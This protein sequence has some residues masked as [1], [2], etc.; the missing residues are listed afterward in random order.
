MSNRNDHQS[1][2]FQHSTVILVAAL[3]LGAIG[4]SGIA[5]A[6]AADPDISF[7]GTGIVI[8]SYTP[9][10][11]YPYS[12][13]VQADGKILVSGLSFDAAFS[14]VSSYIVRHMPTGGLDP[15]FGVDGKLILPYV[16]GS[17]EYR[18]R[19]IVQPDGKILAC[20]GKE[21]GSVSNT[22]FAAFR[23]NSD[24]T[25]DDTFGTGGKVVVPITGA[26]D[27]A[28]DLE[29][30]PD[31]KIVLFGYS[32]VSGNGF[33][34][35]A[36]RLNADGS[37]D[38]TFDSDGR[39]IVGV[40]TSSDIPGKVLVQPDGKLVLVGTTTVGGAQDNALVRVN[41]DGSL[42]PTFGDNGV[43]I[44]SIAAGDD[45][46]LDAVLQADGKIVTS[47]GV[48]LG[49]GGADVGTAIVR[50]NPNGSVD[51]SF[52]TNGVFTTG[53]GFF[54]GNAIVLQSDG[55]IIGFGFGLTS[56]GASLGA[57]VPPHEAAMRKNPLPGGIKNSLGRSPQT[58]ASGAGENWGFA[59][60]RL[61]SNGAPDLS[62]G[63]AGRTLLA[64]G[65]SHND[66]GFEVV[67]QPDGKFLV[68]GVTHTS[69]TGDNAIVRYMGNFSVPQRAPFDFDGDGKTDISIFRPAN[70]EWWYT[71][72]S[73]SAVRAT[74]FGT[75]NDIVVP[76]DFTGDHKTD[77]AVWRPATGEW[78]VLRSEDGTY[79]SFP[80][81][82][83][84]DTPAPADYDG[85]GTTDHA[86]Y[87]HSTATW[88]IPLSGKGETVI[89][90]FGVET[91]RA[92]PADYDGDGKADIAIWRRSV[93]EWWYV[94][95]SDGQ[96][97]AVQFGTQ[98][99]RAVPG[100]YTGDGKSDIAFWR[101]S[102]GN[103]FILRSEDSSYYAVPF[104]IETDLPAPGDYDGDGKYDTTVFRSSTGTWYSNRSSAGLLIHGFG[105]DGDFPV[106][107]S[108]VR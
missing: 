83:T 41:A 13:A 87:R 60:Q 56:G 90:Q 9:E 17:G 89:R 97:R 79:Y 72:S 67:F 69:T 81:G 105:T 70:F 75:S 14:L 43:V 44:N 12:M 84:G 4:A 34:F 103:W 11:D 66:Y 45:V 107:Y 59:T 26:Y 15:S 21:N 82:A 40:S 57:S 39:V 68:A 54:A 63:P 62:F 6:A 65:T 5:R 108:V 1:K 27:E 25:L 7:G 100:D 92:V 73:D 64:I 96:V 46:G 80:F 94:R 85:D 31:G 76:G 23:Y 95:S 3:L 8:S 50:Y 71:Q 88:Y 35:S 10:H 102:D 33:D 37:L 61:T 106:P 58:N 101:P 49:G 99:D 48:I 36:A 52:A 77:I 30:Q 28:Y 16:E 98:N 55:K 42:D 29:L 2:R 74:Q 51:T 24:G 104:G 32:F 91:D 22:D 78:Y 18:Y 38:N 19:V 93:G 20:G 47:G 86:V 53:L